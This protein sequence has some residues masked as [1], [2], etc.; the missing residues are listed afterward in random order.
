MYI[1]ELCC[2]NKIITEMLTNLT[3]KTNHE[4]SGCDYHNIVK[5][6][7]FLDHLGFFALLMPILGIE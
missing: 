3:L 7:L 1:L 2:Y 6:V 5:N 4:Q